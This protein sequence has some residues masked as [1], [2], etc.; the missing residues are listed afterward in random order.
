MRRQARKP[1]R[2]WPLYFSGPSS[3]LVSC[4][5]FLLCQGPKGP[6]PRHAV[7]V[8]PLALNAATDGRSVSLITTFDIYRNWSYFGSAA[9]PS[10]PLSSDLTTRSAQHSILALT[11]T[12]QSPALHISFPSPKIAPSP[13][14]DH[15]MAG[16][17]LSRA[18]P[19]HR[20][21]TRRRLESSRTTPGGVA[22]RSHFHCR[23]RSH[24]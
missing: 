20:S 17:L 14:P 10:Q 16:C 1:D 2:L 15:R 8:L 6:R 3:E 13:Q 22:C 19:S 7:R 23:A 24:L 5:L 9:A 11:A 18:P 21:F 4:P 12:D